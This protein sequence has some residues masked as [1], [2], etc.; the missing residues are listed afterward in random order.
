MEISKNRINIIPDK[1]IASALSHPFLIGQIQKIIRKSQFDLLAGL[2]D[3]TEMFTYEFNDDGGI[4]TSL[5]IYN[6]RDRERLK[7][8]LRLVKWTLAQGPYIRNY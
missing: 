2:I 3:E 4:I 6:Y 8:I 5:V 7:E 1:T